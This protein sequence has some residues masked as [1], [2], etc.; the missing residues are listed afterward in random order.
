LFLVACAAGVL[1]LAPVARHALAKDEVGDPKVEKAMEKAHELEK[2]IV[3]V[4]D[5][6]SKCF[7]VIGGGS[8]IVVSEDGYMLTNHHVAGSKPV[9]TFWTVKIAALGILQAKVIGH[10]P[11]GDITLLQL[12][13]KSSFDYVPLA[14]SDGVKVGD[15]ALALGNPFGY[16]RDS[17]PTVTQGVVS[18]VH[19]N[20][21][22]YTDAIQ[23]DAPINPGNSGGPLLNREGQLIGIN[24]MIAFRH[25]V[26]NNTGVGFAIPSNQIKRFLASFKKDGIVHHGV[27]GGLARVTNTKD[28]MGGALVDSVSEDSDAE[29]GGLKKGDVI[30][31]ADGRPVTHASRFHGIIGTIPSGEKIVLKVKRGDET[32]DVTVKLSSRDG[33]TDTE[34][35]DAPPKPTSGGAYLGVRMSTEE[36]V[37]VKI[38]EVLE[39]SPA[40]EAGLKA[41]DVVYQIGN[42]KVARVPQLVMILS[43]R[44]PGDVVKFLF[45]RDGKKMELAVKLGKKEAD[46]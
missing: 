27:V 3:T 10:D 4:V 40:A 36:G 46:H 18:V 12:Q 13:G 26:K 25:G 23:T 34:D 30:L 41:G 9:G 14:D 8:G 44:K 16:A 21:A 1:A 39:K 32:L 43:K 20:Y 38:D 19:R 11:Y 42:L 24:G 2:A 45:T 31:E 35:A 28:G 37:G 22:N 7:V 33:D 6:T 29:K 15:Y 5:R 17:T